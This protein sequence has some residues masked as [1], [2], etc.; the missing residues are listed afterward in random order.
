MNC[1]R[2]LKPWDRG[3]ESHLRHGCLC[4]SKGSYRLCIGPTQGCRAA[5]RYICI[6]INPRRYEKSQRIFPENTLTFLA[7]IVPF[8]CLHG[9]H[10]EMIEN[11]TTWLVRF[12]V[13]MA[14]NIKIN[15][16]LDVTPRSLVDN[17]PKKRW[18]I[19]TTLHNP[20]RSSFLF[21]L[22]FLKT[23]IFDCVIY[24]LQLNHSM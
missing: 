5:D 15:I 24:I 8:F 10:N 4:A 17:T 6:A 21:T 2:P 7:Y 19:S 1:R 12:E 11:E 23:Q 20:K 9:S 3:L 16:F 14:I 18:Y 13:F 22:S